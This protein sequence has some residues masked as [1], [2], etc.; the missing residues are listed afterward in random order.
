QVRELVRTEIKGFVD[1]VRA[2]A[3][4]NLVALR[5]GSGNQ[6]KKVMLAAHLDEIGVMVTFI[7][8]RGFMRFGALGSVKPLTLLGARVQFANGAIGVLARE[9]KGAANNEI[10]SEKMFIDVGAA[11]AESASIRIG[12]TA[13]FAR[14]AVEMGDYIIGKALHGRIG[15][16]VLIE[17]MRQLKRTP[18]DVYCV[19]TVQ[20]EVGTRGA[21]AAAFAIQPDFAFVMD[22]TAA[23]DIPGGNSSA[24]AL[25]KGPAIKL[26]DSSM[27]ASPSARQALI[28]AAREARVSY[29]MEVT[30]RA[31][32]DGTPIQAAREGVPTGALAIPMRYIH[33]P[34]EMIAFEDAQNAIKL[35][36]TLL[37]KS[38]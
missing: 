4:G 24:I 35:L 1:Q 36:L 23:H 20:E 25:G 30:P 13:C 3:L 17:T 5:R 11:S 19:F 8:P 12:D 15:C 34:S 14:D 29:Q 6:R 33:T 10:Q 38:V 22:A 28:Q 2:D 7:D 37:S 26:K 27:I 21:G 31:G 9:E 18:H 16:A 32:G